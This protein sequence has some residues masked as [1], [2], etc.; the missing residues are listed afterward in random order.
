M[1]ARNRYS[2]SKSAKKDHRL[3]TEIFDEVQDNKPLPEGT[4]E[5]AW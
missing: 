4:K 3:N 2:F 5:K 1:H